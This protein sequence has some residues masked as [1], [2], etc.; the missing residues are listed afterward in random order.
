MTRLV[1][2]AGASPGAGKSTL[3]AGLAEWLITGGLQVDH[4]REEEVLTREA[5]APLAH[6]FTITGEVRLQTLLETTESYLAAADAQGIDVVVTDALVPFVPSLMGWGYSEVAMTKF[7]RE[8]ARRIDAAEPIVVYLDDDPAVAV[9]RAVE[10]EGPGWQDRFLTKLGQYPVEPTVRDLDTACGYLRD[11]RDVTLRLL[12]DLPWQVIV[13]GQTD[14]P[15]A[16]GV[17]RIAR[18]RLAGML[19]KLDE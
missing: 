7:L 3:C 16:N 14:P 11:E 17:Q 9:P 10:R 4:F 18:K 15:S 1:A 12:A 13:V 5:F 8:L 19:A 2:V 6:E